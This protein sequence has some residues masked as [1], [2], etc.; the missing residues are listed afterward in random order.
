MRAIVTTATRFA[1]L[2]V[3][4]LGCALLWMAPAAGAASTRPGW[5]STVADRA[6]GTP[7]FAT[8]ASRLP[9]PGQPPAGRGALAAGS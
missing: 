1:T 8:F 7:R 2:T 9:G 6:G 4:A 3:A 5:G